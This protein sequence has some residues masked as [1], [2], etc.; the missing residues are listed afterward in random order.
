MIPRGLSR[1]FAVASSSSPSI[2]PIA[3]NYSAYILSHV[4]RE[5]ATAPQKAAFIDGTSGRMITY[6]DF[7]YRVG[8][9]ARGFAAAGVSRGTVVGMHMPNSPEFVIAFNALAS[10]G[11]VVTTSNPMYS[12]TELAHQLKDSGASRVITIPQFHPVVSAASAAA[13]LPASAT[14]TLGEP[15]TA[16]LTADVSKASGAERTLPNIVSVDAA[17]TLLAL[18][19]S[20]GTTGLPKGVALSHSNL[21]T[22]IEQITGLTSIFGLDSS[23]VLLGVL[24]FYHI[25][26]I[27][28]IMGS[29]LRIGATV[30]TLPK[31]DPPQ[32]LASIQ[33]YRVTYLPLVPPIISFLAK[34][35]LAA[36]ADLSSVRTVFSGAAPLDAA[37]QVACEKRIP[38]ASVRQGYGMTESAPVTH[39]APANVPNRP[40]SV[41]PVVPGTRCRIVSPETGDVLPAGK[42]NV[43][44]LQISGPQVML[45][46]HNN[47]AATDATIIAGGWLRTGDLGYFDEDGW[48]FIVD[49]L[50][51][52]IKTKG[53]QVAPAELEGLLL[54]HPL[55]YDAAVVPQTCERAGEVPVAFVVTKASMLRGMVSAPCRWSQTQSSPAELTQ[56]PPP[57]LLEP[58]QR[59]GGGRAPRVNCDCCSRLRRG[60]GRRVQAA[61]KC[62]VHRRDSEEPIWEN[63]ASRPPRQTFG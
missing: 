62:F 33:K 3:T 34:H 43:G 60:Q 58:G 47:K 37:T 12:P 35:P 1:A 44:E 4:E 14:L 53:F 56:V 11:A 23:D 50:K 16:F 54:Q 49:R 9:A 7:A 63:S 25:Y 21:A 38:N 40:G 6:G 2:I 45:G 19:Y 36:A 55:I 26:G 28:T 51:E 27:T 20:S 29:P 48:Y 17:K 41:G 57:P 52:L 5:A 10:L 13:G 8:A 61:R 30:V 24:P 39:I 15:S 22:N 42:S 31:F 59:R 32:F 46:Y 18:P